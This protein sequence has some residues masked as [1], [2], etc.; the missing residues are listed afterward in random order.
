[1]LALVHKKLC[2]V[3]RGLWSRGLAVSWSRGLGPSTII[4][5]GGQNVHTPSP[6]PQ[7]LVF[8]RVTGRSLQYTLVVAF[9]SEVLM[10]TSVISSSTTRGVFGQGGLHSSIHLI[11]VKYHLTSIKCKNLL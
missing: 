3:C 2:L 6:M 7:N 9:V 8:A 10:M 5:P 11:T 4:V 1:M